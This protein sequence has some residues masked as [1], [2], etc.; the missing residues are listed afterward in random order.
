MESQPVIKL[1]AGLLACS[2][3]KVFPLTKGQKSYL[4]QLAARAYNRQV[5]LAR[6]RGEVFAGGKYDALAQTAAEQ[7]DRHDQVALA[8]LEGAVV[9]AD[10][11]S[12]RL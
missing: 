8:M 11:L 5:A 6:G 12:R 4:S 7:K 1:L 10:P 2:H 3:I 9:R